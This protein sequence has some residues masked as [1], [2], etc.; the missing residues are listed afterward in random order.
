M[1]NCRSC[2]KE[3]FWQKMPSGN[4][5]PCDIEIYNIQD[6]LVEPKLMIVTSKGEVG[7]LA[8]YG[9]GRISHFA[10]CPNAKIHRKA[11]G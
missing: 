10:T 7:T 3:I 8:K 6:N 9:S 2:G 1:S 4:S 11:K 5:N